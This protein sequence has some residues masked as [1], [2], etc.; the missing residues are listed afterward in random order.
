MLA[1]PCL[2]AA[3]REAPRDNA[4][5]KADA[6]AGKPARDQVDFNAGAVTVTSAENGA[7]VTLGGAGT[8]MPA[9]W[10][11]EFPLYPGAKVSLSF[12][13]KED[14]GSRVVL[15]SSGDSD[16][17]LIAFYGARALAQGFKLAKEKR[18]AGHWSREYVTASRNFNLSAQQSGQGYDLSLQLLE[19]RKNSLPSAPE[20]YWQGVAGFPPGWPEKLLPAYPGAAPDAL[21]SLATEGGLKYRLQFSTAREAP[22]VQKFYREQ[23]R[24]AG[25]QPQDPDP[26]SPTQVYEGPAGHLEV[27]CFDA[28]GQRKAVLT[29]YTSAAADTSAPAG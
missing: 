17:K 4:S 27:S 6:S 29:L 1:L 9:G 24:A 16:E 23:A 14:G 15:L 11:A 25:L 8:S 3:C 12:E 2:L 7:Q 5:A 10:P 19:G 28:E 21:A 22:A 13:R 18:S 20:V 26:A